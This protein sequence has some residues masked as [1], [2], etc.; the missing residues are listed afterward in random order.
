MLLPLLINRNVVG[1]VKLLLSQEHSAIDR[2]I[3]CRPV[4]FVSVYD[5]T[6]TAWM[7]AV[8]HPE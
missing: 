3:A 1:S 7:R 2:I 5:V 6:P 8:D 4:F